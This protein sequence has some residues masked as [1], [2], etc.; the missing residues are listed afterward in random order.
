MKLGTAIAYAFKYEAH[1]QSFF[2]NGMVKMSNNPAERGIK[3]FVLDRKNGYFLP[4]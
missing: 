2:K 1:F 3:T 4:I